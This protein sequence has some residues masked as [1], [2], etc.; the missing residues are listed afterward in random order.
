MT[1][2]AE[3]A[4]GWVS[5]SELARM[6]GRDKA[7]I[8]RRV[9]RLE[10]QGLLKSRLGPNSTKL[11]SVGEFDRAAG[12]A[13][14]AVRELNGRGSSGTPAPLDL[15]SDPGLAREQARRAGLA[16][17]LLQLDLEERRGRLLPAEQ[18]ERAGT[19]CGLAF[20]RVL[21]LALARIDELTSAAANSG[22]SGVRLVVGA[23]VREQREEASRAV[24]QATAP[25]VAPADADEGGQ[26][27]L[28][29]PHT[30]ADLE[31]G[32]PSFQE[33]V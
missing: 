23:L 9:A 2:Q 32:R 21:D 29:E 14:D 17:D 1:D 7:A 24:E 33:L 19:E 25:S 3:S 12:G 22:V 4:I 5:I 18:F 28:G 27:T 31:T 15:A 13:A 30:P 11:V 8:S 26:A 20:V 6:R 10:A 16:A